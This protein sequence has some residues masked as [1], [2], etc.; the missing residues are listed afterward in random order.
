LPDLTAIE[1][2]V[3]LLR[4][5]GHTSRGIAA[6]LGVTARTVEWHLARAQRKLA[7]SA[8][9]HRLIRDHGVDATS[10]GG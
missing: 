8:S 6:Q 4:A 10:E 9:L 2:Q 3:V 5:H 7:H 1:Q